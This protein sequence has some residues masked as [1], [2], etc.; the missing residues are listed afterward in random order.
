MFTLTVLST[1]PRRTVLVTSLQGETDRL[2]NTLQYVNLT[3]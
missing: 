3:Q 1:E 2:S